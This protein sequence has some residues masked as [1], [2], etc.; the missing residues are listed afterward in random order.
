M[1]Y[2]SSREHKFRFSV[3][4]FLFAEEIGGIDLEISFIVFYYF[5]SLIV[6]SVTIHYYYY[7]LRNLNAPHLNNVLLYVNLMQKSNC[8]V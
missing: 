2:F 1:C 5:F 4:S 6:V 8:C 7:S 3:S